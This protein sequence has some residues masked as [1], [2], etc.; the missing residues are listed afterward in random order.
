[1]SAWRNRNRG[2][3]PLATYEQN[4]SILKQLNDMERMVRNR[5]QWVDPNSKYQSVFTDNNDSDVNNSV[6]GKLKK[7]AS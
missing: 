2:D 5:Q 4:K 7:T 1:M 6:L 3:S